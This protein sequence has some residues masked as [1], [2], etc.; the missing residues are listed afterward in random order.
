MASWSVSRDPCL[1]TDSRLA[2]S[3]FRIVASSGITKIGTPD[4]NNFCAELTSILI[5]HSGS[6]ALLFQ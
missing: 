6:G 4:A 2:A 5:F 3:S 1:K